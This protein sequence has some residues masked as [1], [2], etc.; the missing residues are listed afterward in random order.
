MKLTNSFRIERPAAE[1]FDAFLD[2]ERVAT[3]MPGARLV[4]HPAEDTYDGEVSVKVGPLGVSYA[5]QLKVLEVEHAERRL[6]MRAKGRE[7]RGAGNADAYV[8]AHVRDDDGG[9]L[10]EIDTELNIRGKVA[11]FGR[12]VIGEVT[13]GVMQAFAANVAD[14]LSG[15]RAPVGVPSA[16][17]ETPEPVAAEQSLDAWRMLVRPVLQRHASEIATVA[18]AGVAAYVGAR[19]GTRRR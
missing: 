12:G 8:I 19:L 13:D 3:C 16:T 2:I 9:T 6:T 14:L 17:T 15:K 4:G 5:G 1:V 7:Q 18:L 11:Q 10:V